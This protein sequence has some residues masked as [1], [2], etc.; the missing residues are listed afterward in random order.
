[1][2]VYPLLVVLDSEL[3]SVV[4][5]PFNIILDLLLLVALGSVVGVK[6][7]QLRCFILFDSIDWISQ[8]GSVLHTQSSDSV[9]D[10]AHESSARVFNLNAKLLS[11]QLHE[12][13]GV[14]LQSVGCHLTDLVDGAK[15]ALLTLKIPVS[16][17]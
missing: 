3:V 8:D 16:I 6:G 9:H 14:T 13:F 15:S 10:R 4:L 7:F 5:V 1:M 11:S 12:L 2:A 17:S